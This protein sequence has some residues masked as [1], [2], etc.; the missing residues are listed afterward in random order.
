[1]LG[2]LFQQ[3]P[4]FGGEGYY[5]QHFFFFA[6]YKLDKDFSVCVIGKLLQSSVML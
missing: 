6:T 4:S 1:M 3:E 5:S 2:L